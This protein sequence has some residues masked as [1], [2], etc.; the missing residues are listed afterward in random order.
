MLFTLSTFKSFAPEVSLLF[1]QI[2]FYQILY[3]LY[4]CCPLTNSDLYCACADY[5]DEPYLRRSSFNFIQRHIKSFFAPEKSEQGDNVIY[6]MFSAGAALWLAGTAQLL[7]SAISQNSVF[8]SGIFNQEQAGST[9][10]LLII[11]V[12]PIISG[13]V[14]SS[15]LM[16]KFFINSVC[17]IPIFQT[18]RNMVVLLFSIAVCLL[19]FIR[20][21]DQSTRH[22]LY[23]ILTLAST[24]II[25]TKTLQIAKAQAKS[26]SK[27]QSLAIAL[28]MGFL[29]HLYY[30][31]FFLTKLPTY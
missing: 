12:L 17:S 7:L 3:L 20:I 10:I 29:V 19:F 24:I 25:I 16:Y 14:I 26:H 21:T 31:R 30:L 5:L 27:T 18:S 4:H 8:L 2:A 22:V 6:I 11:I 9:L 23:V 1:Y 28:F 13:I 15:Y